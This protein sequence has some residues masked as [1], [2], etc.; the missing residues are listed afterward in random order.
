M[1]KGN[2]G[3]EKMRFVLVGLFVAVLLCG[4]SFA[5]LTDTEKQCIKGCCENVGGTYLWEH[6]GCENATGEMGACADACRQKK[7]QSVCPLFAAFGILGV[8]LIA[9]YKK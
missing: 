5:M 8:A 6:N 4:T 9:D 3:V 1:P 2:D 7:E